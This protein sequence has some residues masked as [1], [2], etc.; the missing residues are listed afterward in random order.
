VAD[1][2]W[3][4]EDSRI[5]AEHGHQIG[6]DPSRHGEW[7]SI[8]KEFAGKTCVRRPWGG[9]SSEAVQRGRAPISGGQYGPSGLALA[10]GWRIAACASAA[11]IA[12]FLRFSL[13][14]T[15]LSQEGCG[16]RGRGDG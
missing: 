13:L 14:E 12:R 5:L 2:V 15:S 9:S 8:T 11:D 16:A 4:S 7:P 3:V 6:W 1:G 10:T